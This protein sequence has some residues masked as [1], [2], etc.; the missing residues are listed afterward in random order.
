MFGL[1]SRT[2]D[3]ELMGVESDFL[4]LGLDLEINA[5]SALVTP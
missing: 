2:L 4:D 3:L 1:Y 5:D